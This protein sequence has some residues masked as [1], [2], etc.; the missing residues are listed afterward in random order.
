MLTIPTLDFAP[1][2]VDKAYCD[3]LSD[4]CN[5]GVPKVGSDQAV[6]LCMDD[7][8]PQIMLFCACSGQCLNQNATNNIAHCDTPCAN[9]KCS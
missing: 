4:N 9:L 3:G 6:F 1:E 2:I 7:N 8:P 5:N